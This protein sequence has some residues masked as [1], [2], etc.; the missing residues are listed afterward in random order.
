MYTHQKYH[1][2]S[3]AEQGQSPPTRDTGIKAIS[4]EPQLSKE[5]C[6]LQKEL[7]TYVQ[8]I[9]HL[10]NKGN[11]AQFYEYFYCVVSVWIEAVVINGLSSAGRL[12]EHVEPDEKRRLE[13]RQQEQA[14][15]SARIIYVLQQQVRT[16]ARKQLVTLIKCVSLIFK[17]PFWNVHK[18]FKHFPKFLFSFCIFGMLRCF[19]CEFAHF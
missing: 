15:R 7:E 13:I 11:A 14:A 3:N 1:P 19:L 8:R 2:P 5:I 10:V 12:A 16:A 9:E 17:V 4:S 6:K 18:L